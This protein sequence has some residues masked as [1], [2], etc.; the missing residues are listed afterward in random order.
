MTLARVPDLDSLALLL[1]VA[2]AGSLGRAAAAHGLSQPAVSARV[3]GM[4]RLVGF[5]LLRRTPRGSSLTPAGALVADWAREVLNAASVLEAGI[6]SL[7]S[8][9]EG[10]LRVAASLTVAEHLLP[11]WLVRLAAAHPET[12]VSLDARNSTD[13]AAAVVAGDAELGFIEGPELP[14][15]LQDR[16]VARDHLVVVVAPGHPWT[17]RRQPLDAQE[18]AATRLVE[19]EPTSGTR[20]SLEAA[21]RRFGDRAAP[22]LELSTGSAVRAAVL[23]GAGPAVLSDL[24]V[25]DDV[26]AGRLREIPVAGADLTRRLR[27]VWPTGQRLTGAARD[28]L[29]IA[30]QPSRAT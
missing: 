6:S 17:R 14:E 18:L 19:R 10:R 20:T 7:R 25:H 24:A 28:L 29:R 13:V 5:P 22:L 1:E 23:A 21:L 26:A 4:E 3:Q 11:R 15:G 9:R 2:A 27:A 12:A 30:E 16:V 8:G